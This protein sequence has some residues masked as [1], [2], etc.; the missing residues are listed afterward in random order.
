M[1]KD[2]TS[3]GGT[4]T[5]YARGATGG[6][7]T[8]VPAW[9]KI[10][11]TP[12][13][14]RPHAKVPN[15]AISAALRQVGEFHPDL[16]GQLLLTSFLKH[17]QVK[18][19]GA[20]VWDKDR[21][22]FTAGRIPPD[23]LTRLVKQAHVFVIDDTGGK[24]TA[25]RKHALHAEVAHT[26]FAPPFP[27]CWFE[28]IQIDGNLPVLLLAEEATEIVIDGTKYVAGPIGMLMHERAPNMCDAFVLEIIGHVTRE[29]AQ[30]PALSK[31]SISDPHLIVTVYRNI[32]Y[33]NVPISLRIAER[34]LSL[35]N[36]GML[37]NEET[38]VRVT[39]PHRKR[40]GERATRDIRRI[41]RIMPKHTN[42]ERVK[43]LTPNGV[44]DW[45]HRW[46]VRGHWRKVHGIGKNR[47]GE[48]IVIGS[49]WVREAIKGPEHLPLVQ[50]T[51]IAET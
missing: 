21:K 37:A 49:T 25:D 16:N 27:V 10:G 30:A 47:A 38:D 8:Y 24:R 1:A 46:E 44:I 18:H 14:V 39:L 34:W 36:N 45:S 7:E 23:E 9:R 29:E 17:P 41:V 13:T 33:N 5:L 43:P 11:V 22:R 32:D 31:V 42:H 15:D 12:T 3:S 50:K 19:G 40:N 48:Y 20:A 35:V 2:K 26:P 51:R 6:D 4:R 28:I